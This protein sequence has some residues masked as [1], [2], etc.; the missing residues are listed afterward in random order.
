MVHLK[1]L[2]AELLHRLPLLALLTLLVLTGSELWQ[3]DRVARIND[4][5]TNA[6]RLAADPQPQDAPEWQIAH[7]LGLQEAG[8]VEDALKMYHTVV[9]RTDVPRELAALAWYNAGNLHL[10]QVMQELD[11]GRHETAFAR[12]DRAKQAFRRALRLEP[13]HWDAKYNLEVV[14]T[15]RPDLPPAFDGQEEEPGE[16]PEDAPPEIFGLPEG[17]P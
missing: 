5:I 12:A 6:W 16:K 14:M 9:V 10:R 13:D 4:R 1:A 15:L 7:A 11:A 17:H 8:R 2:R 3:A